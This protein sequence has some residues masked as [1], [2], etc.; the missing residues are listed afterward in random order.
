MESKEKET[1]K[2]YF[3]VQSGPT[4]AH[5]TLNSAEL[6]G[7]CMCMSE[8]PQMLLGK[9]VMKGSLSK[10]IVCQLQAKG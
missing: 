10:N 9:R 3:Y 7:I 5:N 6:R 1:K 4:H 8:V 2:F